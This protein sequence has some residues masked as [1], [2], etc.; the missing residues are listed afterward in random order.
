MWPISLQNICQQFKMES[1]NK[2]WRS[3]SNFQVERGITDTSFETGDNVECFP[4]RRLISNIY[5]GDS[6]LGTIHCHFYA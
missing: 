2:L 5:C 1:I 4:K 6:T 3:N